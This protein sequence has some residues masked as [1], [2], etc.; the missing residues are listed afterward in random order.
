MV[1]VTTSGGAIPTGSVTC[2]IQ[3]RGH[4]AAYSSTLANGSASLPLTSIG[5][6]PVGT[7]SIACSYAGAAGYA[8]SSTA[9]ASSLNVTQAVP[10][11]TWPSPAAIAYPTALGAAQQTATANVPGTFQY[12][13]A[14][15]TVET[16]G[17]QTLTV[18]FQPSDTTDYM[19]TSATT[20]IVVS[21]GTPSVM[22]SAPTSIAA[23]TAL[24]ATQLDATASVPGTFTYSPA[25]GTVPAVGVD[26][27][28]VTFTPTDTTDYNSVTATTSQVVQANP[29]TVSVTLA[30]I[31]SWLNYPVLVNVTVLD[32]GVIPTTGGT[33]AC[34]ATPPSSAGSP[35]TISGILSP[36]TAFAQ[37]PLTGL[38]LTP[39]GSSYSVTCTF[40]SANPAVVPSG[41]S[42]SNPVFGTVINQP[43]P[44]E[45]AT[46][47]Q[48]QTPTRW[49]PSDAAR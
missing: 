45:N 16:V 36:N 40:T 27:L 7:Y 25:A 23:G 26:T 14:S 18:N 17:T 12:Q 39:A 13:P 42:T 33:I 38:P 28:S 10:V 47:G 9:S 21:K 19:S 20:P 15:G 2:N 6:D 29:S 24:S 11:I 37:I 1:T 49:P 31:T 4:T 44:S 5:Q 22:W 30:P 43:A 8:A 48:L 41:D 46:A 3:T 34:V 35:I 32:A